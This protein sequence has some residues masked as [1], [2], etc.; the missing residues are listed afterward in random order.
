LKQHQC[1]RQAGAKLQTFVVFFELVRM[2]SGFGFLCSVLSVGE[3][4]VARGDLAQG[5]LDALQ[6]PTSLISSI[7]GFFPRKMGTLARLCVRFAKTDGQ[8][9]PSLQTTTPAELS[10]TL[11]TLCSLTAF[12]S[13]PLEEFALTQRRRGAKRAVF[14]PTDPVLCALVPL[15]EI[16]SSRHGQIKL[17]PSLSSLLPYSSL[18]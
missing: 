3:L 18:A 14:Q 2:N 5:V 7:S 15:R 11:C 17:A 6:L 16:F 8:E 4:G 9:C 1:Q 12:T 13:R 10:Q